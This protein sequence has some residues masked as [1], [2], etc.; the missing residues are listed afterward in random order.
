MSNIRV[1]LDYPI[2]DGTIL[3]FRTP[4][5][6]TSVDGLVVYY[7][8]IT[9][10]ASTTVS[11][12]FNLVDVLSTQHKSSDKKDFANG[13]FLQ[14][15]LDVTNGDAYMVNTANAPEADNITIS[16]VEPT[17]TDGRDGDVRMVYEKDP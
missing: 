2:E 15:I 7:R 1:D 14:V 13:V 17:S 9:D 11:K 10:D 4:A 5:D 6:G 16:T 8:Q 3:T 12:T